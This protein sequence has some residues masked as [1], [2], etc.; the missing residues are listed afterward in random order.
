MEN[1]VQPIVLAEAGSE[2]KMPMMYAVVMFN[3]DITTMDFVVD[4]LIKV[5]HKNP[6][7]ASAVMMAIHESGQGVAGVYTY[8]I[9]VTKKIY[10]DQLAAEK[11]FPLQ[12]TIREETYS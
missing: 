5:F 6:V 10:A 1:N 7:D 11:D 8:D 2:V 3:D 9:A 12:M 4:V